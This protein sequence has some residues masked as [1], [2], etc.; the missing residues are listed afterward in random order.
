MKCL[1]VA[2]KCWNSLN[3]DCQYPNILIDCLFLEI[4]GGERG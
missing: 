3:G 2:R 1:Y 4:E